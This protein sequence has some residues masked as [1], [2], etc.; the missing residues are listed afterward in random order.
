[1]SNKSLLGHLVAEIWRYSGTLLPKIILFLKVA[2]ERSECI[3]YV[4]LKF[5]RGTPGDVLLDPG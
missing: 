4:L 1:M 2:S 5:I 3:I